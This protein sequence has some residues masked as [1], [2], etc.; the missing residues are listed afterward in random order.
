MSPAFML[1]VPPGNSTMAGNRANA[2]DSS[3]CPSM[4][5]A[6]PSP[7]LMART[8]TCLAASSASAA[9]TSAALWVTR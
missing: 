4:W 9:G 7:P 5:E 3:N 8:P 6:V 1:A 2:L